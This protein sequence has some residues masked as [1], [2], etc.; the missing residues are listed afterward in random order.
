MGLD[1]RNTHAIETPL[2]DRR[3]WRNLQLLLPYLWGKT[4]TLEGG[5]YSK[6]QLMP[7]LCLLVKIIYGIVKMKLLGE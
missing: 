6:V 4:S 5:V 3:D 7:R 2:A 1:T